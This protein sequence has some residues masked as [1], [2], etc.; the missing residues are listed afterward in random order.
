MV[1][2]VISG[3]TCSNFTIG[4]V[5]VSS[6]GVQAFQG[7]NPSTL[8]VGTANRTAAPS[9]TSGTISFNSTQQTRCVCAVL[10]ISNISSGTGDAGGSSGFNSTGGS[11][12]INIPS[13]GMLIS[14]MCK[15]NEN[16]LSASGVTLQG[17]SSP[18]AG[19]RIG[20]G[21]SNRLSSQSGRTVSWS[22]SGGG[23][24]DLWSLGASSSTQG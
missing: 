2:A 20:W 24:T 15:S 14:G 19:Y 7:G 8:F 5:S 10:A 23:A 12:S 6:A 21:W 17:Q 13:N 22:S 9:G 1:S 3:W 16:S 18:L 4:G 11:V